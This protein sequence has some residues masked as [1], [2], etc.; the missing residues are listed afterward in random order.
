[1]KKLTVAIDGTAGSGKST[2]GKVLAEELGYFFLDTGLLYRAISRHALTREIDIE[3]ESAICIFAKNLEVS[4]QQLQPTFKF[5]LN[6]TT[7]T[8]LYN[9]QIDKIVPIV[10][11]YEVIRLKVREIQRQVAKEGNV[12]LAG[13][14]IGTVVL[15]DADLKFYIEVSLEER[16][17]RRFN[18]QNVANRSLEAI[19]EDIKLR[20]YQDKSRHVSPLKVASDA[21]VINTD[22]LDVE[23]AVAELKKYVSNI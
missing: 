22:G 2:L 8:D 7:V 10:A 15:P 17:R 4:I 21:I 11:S 23:E 3:D 6:Q 5:A 20:D 13:R 14:D 1:M 9:V 19:K 16:A 18:A 12:I